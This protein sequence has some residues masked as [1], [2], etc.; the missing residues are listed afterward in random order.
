MKVVY[1]RT[2]EKTPFYSTGLAGDTAP[3]LQIQR[4]SAQAAKLKVLGPTVM[5]RRPLYSETDRLKYST[6]NI[7]L[8][9]P[10]VDQR[11]E[12]IISVLRVRHADKQSV[13]DLADYVR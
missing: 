2:A 10:E 4:H 6:R 12:L 11:I 5:S 13:I 9:E 1:H 3:L 7:K 8:L